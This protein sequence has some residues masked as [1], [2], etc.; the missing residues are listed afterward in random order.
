MRLFGK[1][2]RNSSE[3]GGDLG[4]NQ[5]AVQSRDVGER[6]RLVPYWERGIFK[7]ERLEIIIDPGVSFGAGDH[8]TTIMAL[9]LLE[10]ALSVKETRGLCPS[11]LDVGTGTGVLA[12]AAKRLG[13][14]LTVGIDIDCAAVYSAGWN[15]RQNGCAGDESVILIAGGPECL[16]AEFRIVA[17]NLA[18]PVLIRLH[19]SISAVAEKFLVLSGIAEAMAQ[20][21]FDAYSRDFD[22]IIRLENSGWHSILFERSDT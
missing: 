11:M 16:K 12:I 18:A 2:R 13:S 3:V 21:V 6:I 22:P 5:G 8:P 9:E 4:V 19:R 1:N 14:G 10:K 20:P 7:S 15:F 17:A